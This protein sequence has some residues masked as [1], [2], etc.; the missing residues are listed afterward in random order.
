MFRLFSRPGKSTSEPKAASTPPGK[1]AYAIGDIHGRLDLLE[2]L[3]ARIEEDLSKRPPKQTHLV[4]LGDLID[5]GPQSKGVIELLIDYRPADLKCH[6]LMG[7]HEDA[8]LRALKGERKQLREWLHHGGDTT[9]ESYGVDIAYVQT[10]GEEALEHALLSAIPN[11]H[12]RF[13]SGFLDSVEFGDYLL[14]HAGIRP[15][16]SIAEQSSTDMRWIR[17]EFL[18]SEA[19]HGKVIVHGHTVEDEITH[20]PNRIGLDTGAYK[21]GVLSAVRLEDEVVETIQVREKCAT[22]T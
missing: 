20:R 13:L 3:L 1:R 17:R 19:D 21:T 6:F 4:F 10:L 8:L 11:S 12:I 5:R 2:Q 16:L 7:N 18:D 14:V 15:G 9:A 22:P